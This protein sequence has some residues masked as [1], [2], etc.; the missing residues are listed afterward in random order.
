M[1]VDLFQGY[2]VEGFEMPYTLEDY[3]RDFVRENLDVL[4]PEERVQ[5]LPAED[6]IKGL[7]LDDLARL[8]A[9]IE[10]RLRESGRPLTPEDSAE[11]AASND[12]NPS[13][14]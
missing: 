2:R 4:T 10:Q 8:Q 11:S 5:G 6:R 3:R 7:S 12:E 13:G 14:H 9:E 1:L